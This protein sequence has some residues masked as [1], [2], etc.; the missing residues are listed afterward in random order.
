VRCK[1]YGSETGLGDFENDNHFIPIGFG[2]GNV[3]KAD[4]RTTA[5]LFIEPQY[6]A[7]HDGRGMPR[8]QLFVGLNLRFATGG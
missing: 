5:N 6:T 7:W 4:A 8:W 2:I 3:W 1:T